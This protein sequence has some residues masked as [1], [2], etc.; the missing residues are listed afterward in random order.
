M[1][2]IPYNIIDTLITHCS[3]NT[4]YLTSSGPYNIIITTEKDNLTISSNVAQ[5]N[6]KA[7]ILINTTTVGTFYSWHNQTAN[8]TTYST[9]RYQQRKSHN[10]HLTVHTQYTQDKS[11]Q[12][13]KSVTAS[14]KALII[15]TQNTANSKQKETILPQIT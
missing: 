5:H 11:Q 8:D 6:V 15:I 2:L 4:H 10:R 13:T 12:N 7:T 1:L 9:T 3:Y 14:Y